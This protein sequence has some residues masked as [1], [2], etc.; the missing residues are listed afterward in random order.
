MT[1]SSD[2]TSFSEVRQNLRKHLTRLKRTGRPLYITTNGQTDAVVLSP[3]A[4]DALVGKAETAEH[5]AA[6]DRGVEDA[7]AGRVHDFR[8]GIRALTA[9]LGLDEPRNGNAKPRRAS[10]R[11]ASKSRR[12][13]A[14]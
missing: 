7:T 2:I 1:R 4:Y 5:L 11:S 14:R 3:R 13:P 10:A 8:E 6:I 9:E 12:K